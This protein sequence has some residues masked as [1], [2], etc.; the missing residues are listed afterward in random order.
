MSLQTSQIKSEHNHGTN[1]ELL[2]LINQSWNPVRA[3]QWRQLRPIF[4]NHSKHWLVEIQLHRHLHSIL[5]LRI[6]L[7]KVYSL[8]LIASPCRGAVMKCLNKKVRTVF[9]Q[10]YSSIEFCR[11]STNSFADSSTNYS[12]ILKNSSCST[13]KLRETL[14]DFAC[15]VFLN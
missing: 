9:L 15:I 13:D 1:K 2:Y 12:T 3:V 10:R 8:G 7:S 6:F 14:C 5:F 11:N 4:V